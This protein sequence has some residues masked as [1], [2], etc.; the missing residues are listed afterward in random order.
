[1]RVLFVL[2]ILGRGM[3]LRALRSR[4]PKLLVRSRA[5]PYLHCT[6]PVARVGPNGEVSFAKL[7]QIRVGWRPAAEGDYWHRGAAASR[8]IW[9]GIIHPP[10]DPG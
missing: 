2:S 1:M 4:R 8:G 3:L 5:I 7:A 10:S 9:N 6:V